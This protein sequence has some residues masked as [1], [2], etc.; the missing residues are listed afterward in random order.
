MESRKIELSLEVP[1]DLAVPKRE[2]RLIWQ[3]LYTYLWL[4]L[5]QMEGPGRIEVAATR[6][7]PGLAWIRIVAMDPAASIVLNGGEGGQGGQRPGRE[8]FARSCLEQYRTYMDG[9]SRL[10]QEPN[11]F[12]FAV[13]LGDGDG[14]D[15]D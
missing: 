1:E 8:A 4:S 14:G 10:R 15:C 13:S 6:E 11:G 5:G 12:C 9:Q 2:Q 3:L 7:S